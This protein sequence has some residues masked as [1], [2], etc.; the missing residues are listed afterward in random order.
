MANQRTDTKGATV[1]VTL[2]KSPVGFDRKQ[3][4]VVRG[5]GLRRIRHTVELKDT[6]AARG[7]IHKV[8]HLVT[9]E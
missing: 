3:L 7:M 8:R 9:V 4:L 6:P 1:K 5:L 2:E